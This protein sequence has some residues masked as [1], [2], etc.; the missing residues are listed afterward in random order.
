M[1]PFLSTKHDLLLLQMTK[2]LEDH[3]APLHHF[4]PWFYTFIY[5][6]YQDREM[7]LVYFP[8]RRVWVENGYSEFILLW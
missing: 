2:K 6:D 4:R 1:G 7:Q 3:Y 5:L 8:L